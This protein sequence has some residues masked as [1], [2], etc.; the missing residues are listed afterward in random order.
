MPRE[1]EQFM[2]SHLARQALKRW[3]GRRDALPADLVNLLGSAS[4]GD[5]F[6]SDVWAALVYRNNASMLKILTRLIDLCNSDSASHFLPI[7]YAAL[8]GLDVAT[9]THLMELSKITPLLI[10]FIPSKSRA[11]ADRANAAWCVLA[12]YQSHAGLRASIV[13][14]LAGLVNILPFD[15]L[16][17]VPVQLFFRRLLSMTH[18][19]SHLR[20]LMAWLVERGL[21][22]VVRQFSDHAED[23]TKSLN[24]LEVFCEFLSQSAWNNSIDTCSARVL[25]DS[26]DVKPYLAEP[27]FGAGISNRLD[28]HIVMRFLAT[29][30]KRVKFKVSLRL[31]VYLRVLTGVL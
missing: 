14:Q 27:V 21:Q 13:S 17:R 23:S 11:P 22:L 16:F 5:A 4:N 12:L 18:D 25:E 28:S 10:T 3:Y 24:G 20:S 19:D 8:D 6:R 15:H 30:A 2:L 29:L 9:N 7:L 31:G 26:R 1:D